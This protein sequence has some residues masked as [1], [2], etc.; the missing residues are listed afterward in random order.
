VGAHRHTPEISRNLAFMAARNGK[1]GPVNLI[2]TPHLV[3]MN[4]GIL[5]TIYIP[6]AESWR[7][8]GISAGAPRPPSK[9]IVAK[10]DDIRTIYADFYQDEPFVRVLPAGVFA[11]TNRVRQSNYCDISVH[12]DQSGGTLIIVS[13]IDNMVKGAAGQAVQNMN[14]IF[15]FDEKY[16]LEAIPALF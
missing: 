6:L 16:G 1:T 11:A 2:F 14:I 9:E 8:G 10:T 7:P 4:R 15:G 3:P 13:A 12:L 5:S